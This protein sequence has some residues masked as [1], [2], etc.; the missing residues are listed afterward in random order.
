[1]SLG[2]CIVGVGICRVDVCYCLVAELGGGLGHYTGDLLW[3]GREFGGL[4]GVDS[5]GTG[6]G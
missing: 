6:V 2:G 5:R 4:G 3:V 1:M